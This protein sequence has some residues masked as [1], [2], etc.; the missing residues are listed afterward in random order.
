MAGLVQFICVQTG[1]NM[2]RSLTTDRIMIHPG[3][4]LFKRASSYILAGEI[5][6]TTRMYARSVSKIEKEWVA[7]LHPSLL[8]SLAQYSKSEGRNE[9][10]NDGR[11]EGRRE[12]RNDS[13]GEGKK[14]KAQVTI[15]QGKKLVEAKKETGISYGNLHYQVVKRKDKS[16][17]I[18]LNWP[19]IWQESQRKDKPKLTVVLPKG[20]KA[21][22]VMTES[23]TLMKMRPQVALALATTLDPTQSV[24]PY[25]D[26]PLMLN[27]ESTQE[28]VE[29]F[30]QQSLALGK[31][32]VGNKGQVLGFLAILHNNG[33]KFYFKPI[34]SFEQFIEDTQE[35]LELLDGMDFVEEGS[36]GDLLLN[37]VFERLTYFLELEI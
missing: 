4:V 13:R 5:V 23:I 2:Y 37:Q 30:L 32:C 27:M 11:N 16:P 31:V 10:R 17:S 20:T 7:E 6:K 15:A 8:A 1:Q 25:G 26:N 34:R 24:L 12:A 33:G 3:S 28:Q 9:S 36:R 35:A 18:S 19:D 14:A 29:T 21:Q 22:L